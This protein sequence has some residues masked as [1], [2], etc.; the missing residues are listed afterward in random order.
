[1]ST[2]NPSSPPAPEPAR[3]SSGRSP[4]GTRNTLAVVFVALV[5]VAVAV[6]GVIS[7]RSTTTRTSATS[8]PGRH[9][10]AS[11]TTSSKST[12]AT[13]TTTTSPPAAGSTTTSMAPATTT[14]TTTTVVT[15]VA[16]G[17]HGPTT[18][19]PLPAPGPG[20]NEGQVTAVGD[21]VML[22]YA[23]PLQ[24][25]IPGINVQAAVS[26][27]W[28]AGEQ[29]LE[30]LKSEGQLGAVVIVGL[31][32]NGPIASSDFSAMMGILSGASRVVFVTVH[33]DRPWQDSN[34]GILATG[35]SQYPHAVL[36]DWNSLVSQN[37]GW[38]YSDGTHL[39]IDGPGAQALASLVASKA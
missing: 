21:S 22:D 17:V 31:S 15:P 36:A 4:W 34:N 14:T 8:S 16:S 3:H 25:D 37:P 6:F 35:V 33:V 1:M 29:E 20:F 9:P 39:P 38:L 13:S 12:I 24:Q 5:V 18:S 27:Q 7:S 26:E 19:P 11:V 2:D 32:T 10:A 23:T 30:T 28:S